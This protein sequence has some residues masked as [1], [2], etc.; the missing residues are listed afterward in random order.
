M[1]RT[2]PAETAAVAL[3]ETPATVAVMVELP[4]VLPVT[5]P[6]EET[7][8]TLVLELLQEA[9]CAESALPAA[10]ERE[11]LSCCVPPATRP[12]EPGE[13]TTL[14]TAPAETLIVAEAVLPSA[15]A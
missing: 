11:T 8:A 13:T 6:L 5:M 1:L 2:A 14:L 7:V 3:P 15:D 9:D 4:G 10:S 12:I